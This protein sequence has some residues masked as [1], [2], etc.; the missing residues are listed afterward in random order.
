MR[1]SVAVQRDHPRGSMLCCRMEKEPLGGGHITPFAQEKINGLTLFIDR[2]IQVNPFALYLDV[3]FIH[4]PGVAHN[5]RVLVPALFKVRH[6]A[7][8]ASQDGRVSQNDSALGHHLDQVPGAEFE[9]QVPPDAKDDN[10]LVKMPTLEEILRR[11]R[12][13]HSS[14]YRRKLSLS[15]LHQNP[16]YILHYKRPKRLF[17]PSDHRLRFLFFV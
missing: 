8:H 3:G 16:P 9:R 4:S 17:S 5:P 14:R 2:A 13:C 15:S 10:S 6:V 1:G 11:G 12:F 7:L